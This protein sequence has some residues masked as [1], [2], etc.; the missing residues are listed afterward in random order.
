MNII[1]GLSIWTDNLNFEYPINFILNSTIGNFNLGN[2]WFNESYLTLPTSE[3]LAPGSF[4]YQNNTLFGLQDDSPNPFI[5]S[6]DAL[7]NIKTYVGSGATSF[8][9][10][11]ATINPQGNDYINGFVLAYSSPCPARSIMPAQTYTLCN[12]SGKTLTVN[13][14]TLNTTY[15]WYATDST[16]LTANTVSVIVTPTVS[17]NYIAYVDSAG[18]KHTEHFSVAVLQNPKFDS[19]SIANVICGNA[20]NTGGVSVIGAKGGTAPYTYNSGGAVQTS[21]SLGGLVVGNYT[22]TVT[23]KNG[24]TYQKPF[25]IKQVNIASANFTYAPT[26]I[27]VNEPVAFINKSTNTN[28][29]TWSFALQDSTTQNPIHVFTDTGTYQITLIAWRNQRQCSDTVTKTLVVKECPSDSINLTV[30]NIFT[31]NADGI[32]DEWQVLVYNINY[33]V[34]NYACIIYDRWGIKVFETNNIS[35]VWNGRTTSGMPSSAGAYYYI[36]KLTATNSKGVSEQKDFKG[37]VELVR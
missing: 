36:I 2:L 13:S 8:S 24:C 27:C 22:A 28:L 16:L 19:L 1:S 11:A 30:P 29:Q 23:D 14:S 32:N 5:D 25:T 9:L 37:Y 33:T 35:G 3:L 34:T 21:N 20:A 15:N 26:T 7:A 17:T 6:T 10:S 31:P 4:Y 12:G 18:C